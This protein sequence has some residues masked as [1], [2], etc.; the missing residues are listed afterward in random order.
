MYKLRAISRGG[1]F[2]KTNRIENFK[3]S[4]DKMLHT[5][6]MLTKNAKNKEAISDF[7]K[8]L[9]VN[10]HYTQQDIR[11]GLQLYM[12]IIEQL[13]QKDIDKIKDEAQAII[14]ILSDNNQD[15][16][17][18]EISKEELKEQYVSTLNTIQN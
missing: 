15:E 11:D 14:S 6:S 4:L 9:E 10:K 17:K 7:M 12:S 2:K 18:E 1:Y 13:K 3:V 16:E 5:R 8:D